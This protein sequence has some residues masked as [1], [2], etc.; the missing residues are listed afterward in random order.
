LSTRVIKVTNEREVLPAAEQG[1]K[2]LRKGLLVG[3]ATETVYGIAAAAALPRTIERL[4]ELKSRPARPF[5]VHIGRPGD[6]RRYVRE[7]PASARLLIGRAWPGP[8]TLL[9]PVGGSL[10]DGRLRKRK[11][12]YQRLCH[13]DLI[14][15]RCPDEPVAR[16][17]LSHI[18]LPIVAPSANL[19]GAPSPRT[20]E[21]VLAGLDG[22][23]DLLID[24]GPTRYGKDSTIVLC[25]P[26]PDD[27]RVLREG[28]YDAAAIGR[29]MSRTLLFVCTGNT[30]RSPLAAGLARKMLAEQAGCKVGELAKKGLQVVS[31]G[32]LAGEGMRAS[33]EAVQA[34]HVRGADISHHRS[35]KITRELIREANMV[36][37]M[38]DAHVADVVDLVP[39][40]AAKTRLLDPHG[41]VPDPMGGGPQAYA[42]AAD[43][44]EK[45]LRGALREGLS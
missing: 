28:V 22:R 19:A 30:C 18:A 24:S 2:A 6:A 4:R 39:E 16:A 9:V 43:R 41:N 40:A 5:S 23:I 34:A 32:V 38:T 15:L 20:A 45:A 12:L 3:F 8:V 13:E 1:A 27:W 11:G 7:M 33:P 21:E 35:R 36:F 25:G 10:A 17:M 37:C 29:M 44:I 14:G 26:G 31:A 42:V